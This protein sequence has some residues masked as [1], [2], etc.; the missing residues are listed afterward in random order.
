MDG[1][2]LLKQHWNN[3]DRFPKINKEEIR[4]MLHQRSS[5][6]IKWVFIISLIELSVGIILG[7]I[8]PMDQK[9]TSFESFLDITFGIAFKA[10]ILYFIY[11]FFK[12]YR[13]IK[14][15]TNTK[16]LLKTILKTR[17]SVDN[18]IKFNIYFVIFYGALAGLK[19]IVTTIINKS[20]AEGIIMTFLVLIVFT[21]V[22]LI[23]TYLLKRY[24]HIL[25][26]RLINKLDNN[27]EELNRIEK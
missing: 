17:Q 11:R 20:V 19:E 3:N 22:I 27:Y 18:Y 14:N 10:V 26:R 7:F 6:I 5:S 2:D 4:H 25:Y 8:L 23:V 1:L 24:Y 15:T 13:L 9:S 21:P 12:N 16:T